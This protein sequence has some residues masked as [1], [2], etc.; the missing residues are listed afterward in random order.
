MKRALLKPYSSA[1]NECWIASSPADKFPI[2]VFLGLL[3]T[4]LNILQLFKQR[5]CSF[6]LWKQK[7]HVKM[8]AK[9]NSSFQET[10]LTLLQSWREN[11][12]EVFYY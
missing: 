4:D 9:L 8:N 1:L 10:S 5:F 7:K 12:W 3:C 6:I 11:L 2:L